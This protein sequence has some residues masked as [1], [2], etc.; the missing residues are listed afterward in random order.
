L[1]AGAF[2]VIG[3]CAYLLLKKKAVEMAKAAMKVGMIMA[4]ISSIIVV[5]P[6]GHEH[7]RQVARTQPEKF[8][9]IEGLYTSQSA[10]PLVVFAYPTNHPP[11]LKAPI[12]IPGL[13]SWMAFGNPNA[14]IRGINEFPASDIPPLWLTFVS[15]HNMVLLGLLFIIVTLW[16]TLQLWRNKIWGQKK[17]LAFLVFL[18]PFPLFAIE[19]GWI[20]AEV[21]RQPWIVYKLMRTHDAVSKA[22]SGEAV[23]FSIILFGCIYLLLGA[24]YLF[25]MVQEI[26]HTPAKAK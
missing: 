6:F 1:V 10:A 25:L 17:F 5:F 26:N 16:G 15:F 3:V 11:K 13:L 24:L 12:H 19:L 18:I 8:A 21:G 20:T 22:V 14:T 2:L 4:V 7:A 9:A 23:L